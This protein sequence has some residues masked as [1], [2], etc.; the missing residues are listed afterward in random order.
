[1]LFYELLPQGQI[2]TGSIHAC[3]LQKLALA[4]RE[5]R[6]RRASVH[7]FLDN[8]RPYAQL[9]MGYS[10]SSAATAKETHEKLKELD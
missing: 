7:L 10:F 5:K 3:Q 4:V 8:A 9:F 2:V 6:P 1:M